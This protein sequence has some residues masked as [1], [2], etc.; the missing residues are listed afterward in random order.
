[1]TDYE[2]LL[3]GVKRTSIS[4]DREIKFYQ[5]L[6]AKYTQENEVANSF[7]KSVNEALIRTYTGTIDGLKSGKAYLSGVIKYEEEGY[8]ES[9]V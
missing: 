6:I 3:S 4:I 5:D 1:M 7:D 2:T 9:L 8:L